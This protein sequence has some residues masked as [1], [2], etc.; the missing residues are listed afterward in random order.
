MAHNVG[1]DRGDP[2]VLASIAWD[3]RP[4]KSTEEALRR[5]ATHD[6]LTDCPSRALLMDRLAQAMHRAERRGRMVGVLFLDLDGFKQINDTFGH[7]TANQVLREVAERMRTHLRAED[8]VARYGGDEFV[9]VV[10]DLTAASD[11]DRAVQQAREVLA[12]PVVVSGVRIP[13]GAS[14]GVA[15]YPLDGKDPETLLRTADSA[16]Y[17]AKRAKKAAT[18]RSACDSNPFANCRR[19]SRR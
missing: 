15:L 14:V 2:P 10:P 8:T 11:V 13:V 6:A 19:S 4:Y 17:Q 1:E 12:E 9:L 18:V 16:M 3:I 5:Q 7:E